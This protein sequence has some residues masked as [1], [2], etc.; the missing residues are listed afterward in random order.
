MEIAAR[1]HIT[2]GVALASA[3]AIAAAPMAQHLPDLHLGQQL[4]QVSVADVQLADAASG[5]VDLFAGVENQLASLASGGAAAAAVPAD[6]LTDVVNPFQ[7]WVNTF[8]TAGSNLQ[9]ILNQFSQVPFPIM[10]Q[11][12][13]N[14]IQYASDYVGAYQKAANVLVRQIPQFGKFMQT[15]LADIAAGKVSTGV[16]FL[17]QT[18]FQQP[19][20]VISQP[21][22]STLKIPAYMTQNLANAVNYLTSTGITDFGEYS[23]G[24]PTV[25]AHGLATALQ[26]VYNSWSAGDLAGTVSNL[27]NAPG[28]VANAFI[29]GYQTS[30]FGGVTGG[31]LS[32]GAFPAKLLPNGFVNQ[33]LNVDL[34]Q[35]ATAIVA[36]NAQNMAGGGSL[37]I[38]IQ[39][40]ASQ[41]INGWPAI[42]TAL[43]SITSDIS[44]TLTSMLQSLPSVLSSL[45]ST[46]GTIATQIGTMIIN[47][48]K[49]L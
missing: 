42:N 47:L 12:A 29:N 2:A 45:P 32:S 36:P 6:V 8:A 34:P 41:L 18:L 5:I 10:Q 30:A 44:G 4:R 23:L 46:L 43:S 3:A 22:E 7:T 26:S 14:G 35:L 9:Y 25:S 17:Y 11:V 37:T 15:G 1:P 39:N 16:F 40:F 24:L 49:L 27:A 31:L 28:V 20:V 19:F 33:M 48:L 38:A 21:L 13:A